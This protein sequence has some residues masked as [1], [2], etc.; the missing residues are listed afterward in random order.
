V[1]TTAPRSSAGPDDLRDVLGAVGGVEHRLRPRRQRRRRVEQQLADARAGGGGPGLAGHHDLVAALAQ[2]RLEQHELRRLPGAL[3]ALEG[4]EGAGVRRLGGPSRQ[5]AGEV[6]AQRDAAT[7]VHLAV[8][9][10]PDEHGEQ[11]ADEQDDGDAV[12][13]DA[14]R[15]LAHP[16]A[17]GDERGRRRHQQQVDAHERLHE[18]EHPAAHLVGD[19]ESE[20]READDVRHAGE[21]ADEER[22]HGR[23]EQ[24]RHERHEDQRRA[25]A[26]DRRPEDPPP[27]QVAERPRPEGD[28][29]RDAGEDRPEQ[30]RV[31]RVTTG[32][33]RLGEQPAE[34]DDRPTGGEGAEHADE[35]AARERGAAHEGQALA[36]AGQHRRALALGLARSAGDLQAGHR[37][38]REQE[39]GG[40]DVEGEVDR[41]GAE[42]LEAA[43]ERPGHQAEQAEH[44]RGD[45]RGAVRRDERE[46]VGALEALGPDDVGD[47]GLLGRDPEQAHRLDEEG[48]HQQVQ[49]GRAPVGDRP[50]DR[51][52]QEQQEA[53]EVADDHGGAPVQRSAKAPASGPNSTAG[54]RRN[55]S[56]PPVANAL[57]SNESTSWAASAVVARKPSQSPKL[58]STRAVY[59]LRKGVSRSTARGPPSGE[60]LPGQRGLPHRYRER[61]RDGHRTG[62]AQ[63]RGRVRSLV[64]A[65]AAAAPA[66]QRAAVGPARPAPPRITRC[67]S[68]LPRSAL[69]RTQSMTASWSVR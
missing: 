33:H 9:D 15:S 7:V 16:D 30:Q 18:P 38:R 59:S 10:E 17:A 61:L 45:G 51:D 40:V 37:Q 55:T 69:R 68:R 63:G 12:D 36:Q 47:R 23:E 35:Q 54:S 1:S 6:G 43:A 29:E 25:G 31:R 14:E 2:P 28:A 44:D 57:P 66:P 24:V 62:S 50:D 22:R 56:T 67:R 46:L 41:T 32:Q 8:G 26:D 48:R 52:R 49:Q 13:A 20:Q 27:R 39:G 19:L 34:G 4:D 60:G 5:P 53:Q 65:T 11:T 42:V 3:T 64:G 21:G 58:D